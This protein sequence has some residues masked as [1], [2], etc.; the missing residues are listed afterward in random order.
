MKTESMLARTIIEGDMI[1]ED[2][3]LQT[4]DRNVDTEAGCCI[5][6][7]NGLVKFYDLYDDVK[8]VVRKWWR[9]W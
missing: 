7:K 4:V 3:I 9:F 6:F 5:V 1:M 8:L 2:G